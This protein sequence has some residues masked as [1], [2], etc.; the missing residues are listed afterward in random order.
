MCFFFVCFLAEVKACIVNDWSHGLLDPASLENLVV[1]STGSGSSC[2]CWRSEAHQ[3][4]SLP[5]EASGSGLERPDRRLQASAQRPPPARSVSDRGLSE[6]RLHKQN[7]TMFYKD[8]LGLYPH[9][10]DGVAING[11]LPQIASLT[12]HREKMPEGIAKY[13]RDPSARGLAVIDW[14]EWRPIWIRNWDTKAI[15][16]SQSQLLVSQ[17]KT[18]WTQTQI[19]KVAQQEFEMSSRIFMLETLRL[20]KSL[21]PNQLWGFYLFPDCYNHYYRRSLENYTGRCRMWR[22]P[23]TTSWSG[24]GLKAR[25]CFHPY[26][27][28]PCCVQHPPLASSSETGWRREWDWHRLERDW[29]VLFLSTAALRMTMSWNCWQRWGWRNALDLQWQKTQF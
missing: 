9:F 26:T 12:Q 2:S 3:M 10:Q 19:Y 22:W 16:K 11:G 29:H 8:R 15:Y 5:S 14:E 17:K 21:R 18:G 24:C 7:L 23:G 27:W 13:I 28:S 25:L 20:A 4:A 1:G 6:W